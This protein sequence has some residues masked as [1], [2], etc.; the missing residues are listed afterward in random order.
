MSDLCFVYGSLKRGYW[1]NHLLDQAIFLGEAI[2][3]KPFLMTTVGFPYLFDL[4]VET[5]PDHPPNIQT[6]RVVGEVF[7]VND[8]HI[9]RLDWLEGVSSNHYKRQKEFVRLDSGEIVKAYIYVAASLDHMQYTK[10]VD[11]IKVGNEGCYKWKTV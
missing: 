7:K 2:T 3:Q 4:S 9:R 1:N 5:I 11:P 10:H 8:D 6:Y